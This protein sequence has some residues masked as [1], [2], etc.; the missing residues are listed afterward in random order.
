M[1]LRLSTHA[2]VVYN[3]RLYITSILIDHS[4]A[5]QR[6]PLAPLTSSYFEINNLCSVLM[7]YSAPTVMKHCRWI[8][9]MKLVSL[10]TLQ[11]S[12][13]IHST[14]P[15]LSDFQKFSETYVITS[16]EFMTLCL[17]QS[18]DY[19]PFHL[20]S[21][22]SLARASVFWLYE[23]VILRNLLFFTARLILCDALVPK[24]T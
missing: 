17:H 6:I 3:L 5:S 11:N 2:C 21:L 9:Q 10:N 18:T 16:Y 14:M 15:L 19:N 7:L 22:H 4:S 20:T 8:I 23:M 12:Y 24:I 13:T 1:L